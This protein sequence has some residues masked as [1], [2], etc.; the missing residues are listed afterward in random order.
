[1]THTP[2]PWT[3]AGEI[4]DDIRIIT[5]HP[6]PKADHCYGDQTVVGSSEWTHVSDEDARLIAAAPDLLEALE[7]FHDFMAKAE[8]GYTEGWFSRQNDDRVITGLNSALLT[9]GHFRSARAAI[10]KAREE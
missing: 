10:T 5:L 8:E 3:V 9:V 1:M 6:M 4:Y 2:G 7:A